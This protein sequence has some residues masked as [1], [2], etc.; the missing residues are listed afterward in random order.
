MSDAKWSFID[1]V[2]AGVA[3]IAYTGNYWAGVAV[4]FFASSVG[5]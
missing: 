4:Y 3:T 2:I 5:P 1:A